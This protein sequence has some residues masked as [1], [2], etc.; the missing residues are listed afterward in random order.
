MER[1][2]RVLV[3]TKPVYVWKYV[4][5]CSLLV[6]FFKMA[7][8]V[9]VSDIHHYY[10]ATFRI[11]ERGEHQVSDMCGKWNVCLLCLSGKACTNTH[12]GVHRQTVN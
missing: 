7:V 5:F 8:Q 9:S 6:A 12:R 4:L 10:R 2:Q 3:S 1:R 11:G